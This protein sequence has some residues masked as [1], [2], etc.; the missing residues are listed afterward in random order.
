MFLTKTYWDLYI[1]V[2]TF[3]DEE[4]NYLTSATSEGKD[5][6]LMTTKRVTDEQSAQQ[7]TV[8]AKNRTKILF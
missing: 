7:V 4:I 2:E 1:N 8:L 6:S 3:L 5:H